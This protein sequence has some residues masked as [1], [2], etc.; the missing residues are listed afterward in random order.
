MVEAKIFKAVVYLCM[1]VWVEER[2]ICLYVCM[3]A[4]TCLV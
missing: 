2:M 3:Y 4:S 1:Y